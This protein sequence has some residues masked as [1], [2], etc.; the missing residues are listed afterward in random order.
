MTSN[1]AGSR[2]GRSPVLAAV[3]G[4][5]CISASAV[6][7]K[8]ANT[9]AATTGLYR[10][11]LAL[12]LLFT[13]AVAEQ[14]RHGRRPLPARLGA[15]GAGLFLAVDL[16]LWNHAIAE[17]GAGVA[18]V[19]GNLQVL[20]VTA[21]AWLLLRERPGLKFLLALPVVMAGV[22]LV[23]GLAGAAHGGHAAAGIA[24]GVGTSLAYA[25]FLLVF[26]QTAGRTRHVA[27]PLA[28][29]TAGAAAGSVLLGL[30]FGGLS[31]SV[32]WPSFGWLLLLA[33]TSQTLGWLLITSSLPRLPAALSSLL[34][35]LQPAAAL[36]LAAVVL[37]ERPTL[38]QLAGAVLV[39]GGVLLA[40]KQGT[41]AQASAPAPRPCDETHSQAERTE[42]AGVSMQR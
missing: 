12:P 17:V 29:A 15:A 8:L 41:Q 11:L 26:R 25:C 38:L 4:A 34:L 30:A 40:S 28:D 16:V 33:T 20:F 14:R 9:G 3:L 19:L 23:S 2:R 42:P 27:G 35:L 39:C 21:A 18:T 7:V 10:C 22:V 37:G 1:G 13:L 31:F 5:A 36:V 6:L 32:P 24:Y